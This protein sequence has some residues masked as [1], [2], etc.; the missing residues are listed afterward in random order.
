MP[1]TTTL[2][3]FFLHICILGLMLPDQMGAQISI[4]IPNLGFT[5]ACAGPSFNAYNLSFSFSPESELGPSNQ[6]MIEM[7]DATGS[8]SNANVIFTSE[9]GEITTSPATLNFTL[10]STT[11]GEGYRMRIKSTGPIATSSSS[12]SFAA[13]YKIQ[14]SPFS[15]NNLVSTGVFCTGSSYVLSIDNPGGGTND[16]PLNYPSLTYKWYR[17]TSLTTSIYV[18]DG[19]TLSVSQEGT[20]FVK[21]NYGTCTSNSFSNRV[22]VTEV[23][24]GDANAAIVSSKGNPFCPGEGMTTLT[25][26]GGLSYQWFKDGAEIT[27]ATHQM[28]QTD[29][30]GTYTVQVDLGSCTASGAIDLETE[31]FDSSINV[32][33]TTTIQSGETLLIEATT[34]AVDP[35]FEW[36]LNDALLTD[37]NG[38]TYEATNF[39]DYKLVIS[40]T[41]GCLV[42]TE[43]NFKINKRIEPFPEVANIPNMISP[44]GDG[45][46]D[47]WVI[48]LQYVSGTNTEVI[49]M[50][51]QGKVVLQTKEYLNNWPENQ[52]ELNSI[53]QVYYYLINT[54]DQ[55]P[56]KGSITVV[57]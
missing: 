45:V 33:E 18:G 5:K 7:S 30:A 14:D 42:S 40:Q 46:N 50:T 48:P 57:K 13:Y 47:T 52:L 36:Y 41:A 53:N 49:I 28:Y 2:K 37:A 32:S 29:V 43:Y 8:F 3:L 19:A 34:N 22:S 54:Q 35:Y 1:K 27:D 39:G 4:G 44:N 25:T 11:A 6:F 51:N 17:E 55:Q 56:K 20:Y 31:G 24:A 38:A 21:T 15:I 9:P 10:P 16:S 23:S 26:I 12:V